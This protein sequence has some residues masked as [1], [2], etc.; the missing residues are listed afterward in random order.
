MS[1]PTPPPTSHAAAQ[2]LPHPTS[3]PTPQPP[4]QEMTD[5]TETLNQPEMPPNPLSF[6]PGTG[7]SASPKPDPSELYLKSRALLDSKRT[8]LYLLAQSWK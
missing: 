1:Q 7:L 5:S 4:W 8:S 6:P 2:P 3:Q